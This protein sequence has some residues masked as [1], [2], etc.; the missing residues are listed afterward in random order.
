MTR[1]K[2][3]EIVTTKLV[4]V[5]YWNGRARCGRLLP[6]QLPKCGPGRDRDKE[7]RRL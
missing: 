5:D 1:E 6:A 2:F 3:W 7:R 4:W